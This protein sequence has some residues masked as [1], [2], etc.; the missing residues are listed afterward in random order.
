M[1]NTSVYGAIQNI[2]G[3]MNNSLGELAKR[4]RAIISAIGDQNE[5]SSG[6][7]DLPS[8]FRVER[9]VVALYGER[10]PRPEFHDFLFRLPETIPNVID[11]SLDECHVPLHRH[12]V[13][14][15]YN[16]MLHIGI[17]QRFDINSVAYNINNDTFALTVSTTEMRHIEQ[18]SIAAADVHAAVAPAGTPR[19]V[20][21][22]LVYDLCIL[23][24]G[25]ETTPAPGDSVVLRWGRCVENCTVAFSTAPAEDETGS[26]GMVVYLCTNGRDTQASTIGLAKRQCVLCGVASPA[27]L[28]MEHLGH[29]M[30]I[31]SIDLVSIELNHARAVDARNGIMLLA[32]S[33]SGGHHPQAITRLSDYLIMLPMDSTTLSPIPAIGTIFTRAVDNQ[34]QATLVDVAYNRRGQTMFVLRPCYIYTDTLSTE[35]LTVAGHQFTAA[36]CHV[37]GVLGISTTGSLPNVGEGESINIGEIPYRCTGYIGAAYAMYICAR[38]GGNPGP[39]Y[40]DTIMD[41]DIMYDET[42]MTIPN[43]LHG[44]KCHCGSYP[45]TATTASVIGSCHR[46]TECHISV[47]HGFYSAMQYAAA[48]SRAVNDILSKLD[49]GKALMCPSFYI[50]FGIDGRG[51]T[52]LVVRPNTSVTAVHYRIGRH[53]KLLGLGTEHCELTVTVGGS[54]HHPDTPDPSAGAA[55]RVVHIRIVELEGT[56]C[57][58]GGPWRSFVVSDNQSFLTY[59]ST[60]KED[61]YASAH[62]SQF[63]HATKRTLTELRCLTLRFATGDGKPLMYMPPGAILILN[64]SYLHAAIDRDNGPVTVM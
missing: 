24:R 17:A 51:H 2:A 14:H 48:L 10:S 56:L 37:Q 18:Y 1:D 54:T 57:P 34:P 36:G 22:T 44:H 7:A 30:D 52:K 6:V 50:V 21:I 26:V 45:Y 28:V 35:A 27:C 9:K 49:V 29:Q 4:H 46:T 47:N 13:S 8:N 12:N 55:S 62:A 64:I 11:V 20:R 41:N 40:Y 15:E 23:I 3:G 53:C 60:T 42:Q 38:R 32:S 5:E 63:H 39:M 16:D 61:A 59:A 19:G 31:P 25:A 33:I 58:P 43:D